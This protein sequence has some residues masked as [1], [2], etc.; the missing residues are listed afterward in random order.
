MQR[1]RRGRTGSSVLDYCSP[2]LY[3]AILPFVLQRARPLCFSLCLPSLREP[4]GL[5][6]RERPGSEVTGEIGWDGIVDRGD[7]GESGGNGDSPSCPSSPRGRGKKGPPQSM[8]SSPPES[9]SS[10][11]LSASSAVYLGHVRCIIQSD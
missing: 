9:N 10:N 7:G 5:G 1:K 3:F 8:S 6:D 11:I 2:Y 4:L